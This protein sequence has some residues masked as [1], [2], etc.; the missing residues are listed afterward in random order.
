MKE[1]VRDTS[2]DVHQSFGLCKRQWPEQDFVD[3]AEQSSIGPNP[4]G[5]NG[6]NH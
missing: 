6:A 4:E 5:Q 3:Y 2:I 1:P